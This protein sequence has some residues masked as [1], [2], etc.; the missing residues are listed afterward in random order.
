MPFTLDSEIADGLGP[1]IE[2]LTNAEPRQVGD[3]KTLRATMDA[4]YTHFG[5]LLPAVMDIDTAQYTVRTDD[6]DELALFW[7]TK[8]GVQP[9][10]A[11]LYLH[12]GGMIGGSVVGY[13]PAIRRYVAVSGVPILAVD[14]RL[15]P[16]HRH[17]TQV[18]DCYAAL[19]WL[20][21]NAERLGVDPERIA[22]MGDS[23][24]GGLAA[25]TALRSR[26]RGEVQL[27]AQILLYPM[28]DNRTI[29]GDPALAP[30]LT[31]TYDDNIT[32]WE[33]L[34]GAGE[35]VACGFPR[36]AEV[37]TDLPPA[38]IEVGELDA[39]RDECIEY[40]HRLLRDTISAEIVVRPGCPHAFDIFAPHAEVSTRAF[41][42][43]ARRLRAI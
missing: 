16:E 34:L 18:E 27:A 12:G 15:A 9:G 26:G 28:L 39:F 32:A 43:R 6:G 33:A 19:K 42:D 38:Y 30:Y 41:A 37:L 4:L 3:W 14:Y 20:A 21:A 8:A 13:T 36:H 40:G 22:V 25:A 10:S 7:F 5:A 1:L 11:A 24:G 17:P 31:W 23:A 35:Q 29:C 2:Q